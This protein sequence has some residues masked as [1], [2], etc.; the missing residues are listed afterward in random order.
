MGNYVWYQLR[1]RNNLSL[2]S[3]LWTVGEKPFVRLVYGGTLVS[4]TVLFRVGR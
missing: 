4:L 1:L 2:K 3:K